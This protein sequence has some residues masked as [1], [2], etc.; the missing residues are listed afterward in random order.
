M[1]YNIFF[2]HV[3]RLR[4]SELFTPPGFEDIEAESPKNLCLAQVYL[5]PLKKERDKVG[6]VVVCVTKDS[7]RGDSNCSPKCRF[8][9]ST[10]ADCSRN[11][12]A[13]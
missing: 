5:P 9:P 1:L 10:F 2:F 8:A 11:P 13:L 6:A 3:L 12:F 4:A 7:P